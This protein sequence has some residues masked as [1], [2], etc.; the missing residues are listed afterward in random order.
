VPSGVARGEGKEDG[1]GG[2]SFSSSSSSP[3]IV[4]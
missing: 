3:A 4:W 2:C 1:V